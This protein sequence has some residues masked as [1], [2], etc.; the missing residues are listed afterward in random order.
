MNQM[1]DNHHSLNSTLK[2][3]DIP[4]VLDQIYNQ[5]LLE[6][7]GEVASYIPELRTVDPEKCAIAVATT[8]GKCFCVGDYDF[9]LAL[10]SLSKP[11]VYGIALEDWGR[12]A[13]IEKVGVS[14]SGMPFDSIIDPV[15]RRSPLQN[16]MGN[17]GAMATASLIKG[18]N[19]ATKWSKVIETLS[20]YMGRTPELN[21][22]LFDSEMA[23]NYRNRSLAF[24]YKSYNL[25][26]TDVDEAIA[27]YTQACSLMVTTRELAIMSATLANDGIN[28][29]TLVRAINARFVR[30]ILSVMLIYGLYD[31][32]GSWI[33]EIGLP[34]KSGVSGGMFA[35]S[36]GRLSIAAY[37]PRLD[38]AGNSIRARMA[39]KAFAD[40][41]ELHLLDRK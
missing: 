4:A 21:Q 15:I 13:M 34:G 32:T 3:K 40:L 25:F 37:S 35:V 41:M 16:P 7:S 6:R 26:Y 8:D 38:P 33:F 28:P 23:T 1:Q 39:I 36:P 19:T 27:R 9:P 31:E 22:A 17:A 14:V 20:R 12:E 30:D 11:F 5:C 18:E 24:L 29:M 10:E 2:E